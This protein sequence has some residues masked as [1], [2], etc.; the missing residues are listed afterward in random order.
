MMNE[1]NSSQNSKRLS[2]KEI[3][4]RYYQRHRDE[5]RAQQREYY[6]AHAEE[7]KA[8]SREYYQTHRTEILL[9]RRQRYIAKLRRQAK[10][11]HSSE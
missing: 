6:R 3:S 7:L 11:E 9:R 5:V 8:K 4:K 2:R 1:N 10:K